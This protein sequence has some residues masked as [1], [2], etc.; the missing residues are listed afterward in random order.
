MGLREEII[1]EVQ[2][3]ADTK[4][5]KIDATIVSRVVSITLDEVVKKLKRVLQKPPYYR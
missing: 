2:K 1:I 4:K 3:K 5:Q